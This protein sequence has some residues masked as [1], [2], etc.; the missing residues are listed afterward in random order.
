M[1]ISNT[2][3][4]SWTP[5]MTVLLTRNSKIL[6]GRGSRRCIIQPVLVA[7]HLK[8]ITVLSTLTWGYTE[9]KDWELQMPRYFRWLFLA[10]LWVS[11]RSLSVLTDLHRHRPVH[12]MLLASILLIFWRLSMVSRAIEGGE[13]MVLLYFL[14]ENHYE[15]NW[16]HALK[17]LSKKVLTRISSQSTR[18]FMFCSWIWLW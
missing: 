11:I 8:Q 12:V 13:E 18:V 10:I 1:L 6:S 2:N 3:T 5:S 16:F 17:I 7:W 14:S 9:S 4:N 15:C